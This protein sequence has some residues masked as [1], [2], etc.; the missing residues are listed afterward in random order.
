VEITIT[1]TDLEGTLVKNPLGHDILYLVAFKRSS[2]EDYITDR[3]DDLNGINQLADE[4]Q[5]GFDNGYMAGTFQVLT[6]THRNK[7][8]DE[9]TVDWREA[10]QTVVDRSERVICPDTDEFGK[11]NG[12]YLVAYQRSDGTL[13]AVP[14]LTGLA[15]V[16]AGHALEDSK[17]VVINGEPVEVEND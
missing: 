3:D 6:R 11:P 8:G 13:M 4:I 2:E 17:I 12:T 7:N 1:D 9:I 15:L 14:S 10:T 16:D 5:E